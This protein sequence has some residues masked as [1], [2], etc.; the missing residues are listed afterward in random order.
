MKLLPLLLVAIFGISNTVGL[1]QYG[2]SFFDVFG[3]RSFNKTWNWSG[4]PLLEQG[5]KRGGLRR[6]REV[7]NVPNVE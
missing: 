1:Q 6:L 7:P 4:N 2:N 5:W 3:K